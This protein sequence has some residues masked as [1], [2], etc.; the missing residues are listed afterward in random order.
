MADYKKDR[1]KYLINPSVIIQ[2]GNIQEI[3]G[4]FL[5]FFLEI[6]EVN[7]YFYHQ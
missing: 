4:Q 1:L 7:K 5:Q 2:T 6:L 3:D